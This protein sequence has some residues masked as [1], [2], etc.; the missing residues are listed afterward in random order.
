MSF[1]D[2]ANKENDPAMTIESFHPA[3]PPVGLGV[4]A[5]SRQRRPFV[6]AIMGRSVTE[7]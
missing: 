3:F 2:L 7:F 4:F 6:V 1:S 5:N